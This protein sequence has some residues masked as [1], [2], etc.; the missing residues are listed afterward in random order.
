MEER[1]QIESKTGTVYVDSDAPDLANNVKAQ[2]KI[3]DVK[4][5]LPS[6]QDRKP[7]Q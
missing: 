5:E 3:T 2:V 4:V 7:E 6:D 1:S